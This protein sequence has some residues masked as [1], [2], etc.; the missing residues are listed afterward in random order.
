MQ[1]KLPSAIAQREKRKVFT[2][3]DFMTRVLFIH[4]IGNKMFVNFY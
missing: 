3:L 1:E 2:I 4:R